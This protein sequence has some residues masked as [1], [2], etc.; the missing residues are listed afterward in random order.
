MNFVSIRSI[1]RASALF[2]VFAGPLTAQ[3]KA[4]ISLDASKTGAKIDRNLFGQFAENLGY[5]LYGDRKSTRLNS[6]H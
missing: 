5:G 4:H 2:L 1:L 6:S 3:E